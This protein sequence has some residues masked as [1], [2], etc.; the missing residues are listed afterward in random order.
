MQF[1]S[2]HVG[3]TVWNHS[4]LRRKKKGK[5][6]GEKKEEKR[7]KKE[8]KENAG[9]LEV[10]EVTKRLLANAHGSVV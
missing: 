1:A 6:K 3:C 5:K 9:N 2:E 10:V 7:K 8:R 4:E